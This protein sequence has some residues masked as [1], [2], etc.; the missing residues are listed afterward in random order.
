MECH[1]DD[2]L[3]P[4]RAMVFPADVNGRRIQRAAVLLMV[5]LLV[6]GCGGGGGGG[7][8]NWTPSFSFPTFIPTTT[9]SLHSDDPRL[10]FAG[11]L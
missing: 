1:G 6:S 10:Y 4:K 3:C 9:P 7:G 5:G 11:T 8:G 2:G